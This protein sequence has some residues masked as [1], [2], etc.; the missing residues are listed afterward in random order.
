MAM[1][2]LRLRQPLV[3]LVQLRTVEKRLSIGLV[4]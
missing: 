3:F 2:V 4:V 1:A